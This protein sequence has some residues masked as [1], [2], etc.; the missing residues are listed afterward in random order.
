MFYTPSLASRFASRA[1]RLNGY[2]PA[3]FDGF[4][5]LFDSLASD[6]LSARGVQVSSDDQFITLNIDV[7]GLSKEQLTLAI[8]ESIVRIASKDDAP[9]RFKAAYQLSQE[10]DAAA[11][12]AKLE[13]GVLTLKL[14]KKVPESRETLLAIQ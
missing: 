8:E 1:S 2:S 3:A 5:R 12:E 14:A 9:R 10:I 11:S 4:D 6:A 13:H 7:P